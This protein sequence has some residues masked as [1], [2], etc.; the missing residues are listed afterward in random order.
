MVSVPLK[1]YRAVPVEALAG[2]IVIDTNNYYPERDGTV[3]ELEE[4]RTTTAQLLQE[5][6]PASHVVKGFNNIYFEHLGR[7]GRPAGDPERSILLIAA[8]DAG[9]REQATAFLDTL[10]Y[11]AFDTG[12]LS[13]SWRWERDRPAYVGLYLPDGDWQNPQ[14]ATPERAR[15][16]LAEA[17]RGT[18]GA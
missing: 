4:D 7:M 13:E 11:T 3:A 12:P 6:L 1:A 17:R 2:K 8:D 15:A 16:L 10:G 5:H 9:A 18:G 14:P